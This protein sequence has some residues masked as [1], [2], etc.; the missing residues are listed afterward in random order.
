MDVH[1]VQNG[2]NLDQRC[3]SD[4]VGITCYATAAHELHMQDD[5]YGMSAYLA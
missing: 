3:L 4:G 1:E 5:M 2:I